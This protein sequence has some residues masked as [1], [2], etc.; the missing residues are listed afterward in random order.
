MKTR[1]LR[2]REEVPS[3]PLSRREFLRAVGGGIVVLVSVDPASLLAQER[4]RSY[5]DDLNAYLRIDGDGRVSIFSG[6]IEMGQGV[7]TSQAQMAAEELGVAL[8]SIVMVLGDT[9]RCPWDMGTFGSLTTRMFGPVLRAAAAEARAV[10]VKLASE[11]LGVRRDQLV[12]ESGVVYAAADRSKSVSYGELAKGKQ[13]ARLVDE[14]AVLRA[15]KDFRVM[16]RSPKRLDARDKVTGRAQYAGDVRLPGMLY[17]R[18]LRPPAHGAALTRADLSAARKLPGVT[19]VED[20]DLL[21][22]LAADPEAAEAALQAIEAR[23]DVPRTG[24]DPET[25]FDHLLSSAPAP[26]VKA[27]KG[28]P[29]A[30]RKRA[31]RV[32]ESTYRSGY[33]AHAPLEPHAAVA[34]VE[35]GRMTVWAST[36]TPFP[37]RDAV[38]EALGLSPRD[39]RVITPYVGGGFGGKS[40]GRQIV[41]AA[42]L[43]RLTRRPVQVAWTRAEEFFLDTFNPASIV[44]IASAVGDDGRITLWDYGVYC[45]GDR[46]AALSYDV[47]NATVRTYGSWMTGKGNGHPFAVGPWRA[48]GAN[49]NVFAGESQIDLMAVAAKVDPLEFRLR[50]TSDP[51]MRRVLQAAAEAYGW[52]PAAGPTGQGRGIACA[53]DAGTYV[54]FVADVEVDRKS[55]RAKVKRV[56]A[57]QDMGIVVNPEGA[58]MQIEGGVTMGLGYVFTEEVRFK[59][60]EIL[61]RNFGTYVLP[62]FSWLPS[63][64][65][66]L[67]KNDEVLPQGG[68][69]PAIVPM[70]AVVANAIFDATGARLYRLPMTPE[71]ILAAIGKA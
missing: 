20:E 43:A 45:G 57:A 16:G 61:D 25:I 71:R 46:G 53:T 8:E 63:I 27:L 59:G 26:E 52:K 4:S 32:F 15:A 9:D 28:D 66:V 6:K 18:V 13:I 24:L 34:R 12:V 37:A 30:A 23:W 35:D 33:R 65:T 36:Q 40:A 49:T 41:E 48:P 58:K 70:G 17:A 62:R 19:V 22:V 47:P 2:G 1:G 38:A 11:R 54:A 10:L 50:N 14:K 51:R 3:R 29:I 44:K 5:P 64:E 21:A 67:V 31:A 68:G 55:G 42:R 39:V 7:M 69:E 60:G 56:V